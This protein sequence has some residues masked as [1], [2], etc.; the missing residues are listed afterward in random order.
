MIGSKMSI[1]VSALKISF[2]N[3]KER[4]MKTTFAIL[5]Y[6]RKTRE[7]A[8]GQVPL[9]VRITINGERAQFNT[10][11]EIRPELWDSKS[12]KC[13]GRSAES[14]KIN[15]ILD[16]LRTRISELYHKNFD[17][18]GYV[19]PEKIKNII[20]GSDTDRKKMLLGHFNEQNEFYKLKIGN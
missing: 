1:M 3:K 5:F 6:L 8:G 14:T 18:Y 10:K 9:M 15:R 20:L 11:T 16:S 17:E 19:L 7:N 12:G 13:V 2:T 4:I